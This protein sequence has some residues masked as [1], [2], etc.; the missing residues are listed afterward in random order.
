[1]KRRKGLFGRSKEGKQKKGQQS[2]A[3]L[4][5]NT[6]SKQSLNSSIDSHIERQE[7]QSPLLV[8]KAA[9]DYDIL[10]R[11]P[12]ETS[13]HSISSGTIFVAVN[14]D[15][16]SGSLKSSKSFSS[17][18]SKHKDSITKSPTGLDLSGTNRIKEFDELKLSER[19]KFDQNDANDRE[20]R[21]PP[22][23]TSAN[24]FRMDDVHILS[25]MQ[26][27]S[28]P[29]HM[30][31]NS[32]V[33][34]MNNQ[35]PSTRILMNKLFEIDGDDFVR[36]E[37]YLRLFRDALHNESEEW[38]RSGG[39]IS[40]HPEEAFLAIK[41]SA[42]KFHMRWME[43]KAGRDA[44]IEKAA[45]NRGISSVKNVDEAKII[46]E[47]PSNDGCTTENLRTNSFNTIDEESLNELEQICWDIYEHTMWCCAVL[48]K[49]CV[50]PAWTFQMKNRKN[51]LQ[52]AN[53]VRLRNDQSQSANSVV[54]RNTM[55]TR[56]SR[57]RMISIQEGG[58]PRGM[59]TSK[60]IPFEIS[61]QDLLRYPPIPEVLPIS[62]LRFVAW[63]GD[64][65]LPQAKSPENVILLKRNKN[66]DDIDDN[67]NEYSNGSVDLNEFSISLEQLLWEERRC[68]IRRQRL[69]EAQRELTGAL[70]SKDHEDDAESPFD[71]LS[72][73]GR[74]KTSQYSRRYT[75]SIPGS[76]EPVSIMIRSWVETALLG[77]PHEAAR[78]L[79]SQLCQMNDLESIQ[80]AWSSVVTNGALDWWNAV[81]VSRAV[82]DLTL[83][84]WRPPPEGVHGEQC[85]FQ[86]MT[87]AEKG[88]L[89]RPQDIKN[90]SWV[91]DCSNL[92]KMGVVREER[93][94]A[95]T[96]AADAMVALNHLGTRGCLPS[97]TI[98]TIAS[99]LCYLLSVADKMISDNYEIIF[100]I[101]KEYGSEDEEIQ[102]MANLDEFLRQRDICLHEI[103]ELLWSMM[104]R[105]ISMTLTADALVGVL[106]ID[107]SSDNGR[108]FNDKAFAACGAVRSLGASLWGNL[109]SVKGN[110]YLRICWGIFIDS[111]SNICA[112]MHDKSKCCKSP[113]QP[114]ATLTS[115][116]VA[117]QK[118]DNDSFITI[119]ELN[120][121]NSYNPSSLVLVF[122]I[123][124]AV[125]RLVDGDLASGNFLLCPQEWESLMNLLKIGFLPWLASLYAANNNNPISSEEKDCPTFERNRD[126]V[127]KIQCEVESIFQQ[128]QIYLG[129]NE[130]GSFFCDQVLDENIKK[131][132]FVLYFRMISPLLPLSESIQIC[133]SIID[134]WVRGGAITF[135]STDWQKKCS[136]LLAEAFAVYQDAAQGYDGG[137]VHPPFVRQ[138][139]MR[140][141][142]ENVQPGPGLSENQSISSPENISDNT[143]P[144]FAPLVAKSVHAD[145]VSRVL[146]PYLCEVLF[147]SSK[148][149]GLQLPDR[150]PVLLDK[151]NYGDL[152][153]GTQ[154]LLLSAVQITGDL[155]RSFSLENRERLELIKILRKC[156]L[157]SLNHNQSVPSNGL[158]GNVLEQN[159]WGEMCKVKLEAISQLALFLR[160]CFDT[161]AVSCVP[162]VIKILIETVDTFYY[163]NS[164]IS[165]ILPC[166]I[167]C[168]AAMVQLACIRITDDRKA[169]LVDDD[170]VI[171]SCSPAI[172][173]VIRRIKFVTD[174]IT[175]HNDVD[176]PAILKEYNILYCSSIQRSVV[177]STIKLEKLSDAQ[178]EESPPNRFQVGIVIDIASIVDSIQAVLAITS[179]RTDSS[180]SSQYVKF[181]TNNCDDV[182]NVL[183]AIT[184]EMLDFYIQSGLETK[185]L[186]LWNDLSSLMQLGV[187]NLSQY[188]FLSSCAAFVA[189]TQSSAAEIGLFFNHLLDGCA[190]NDCAVSKICCL[191]LSSYLTTCSL[192]PLE[193][194][195]VLQTWHQEACIAIIARIQL[196]MDSSDNMVETLL[197]TLLHTISTYRPDFHTLNDRT[198]A[199]IVIVCHQVCSEACIDQ[200]CPHLFLLSLQC[201]SIAVSTM[202]MDELMNLIPRIST[203]QGSFT[204]PKGAPDIPE[205]F[206]F[207]STIL[208]ILVQHCIVMAGST[209]ANK[210]NELQFNDTERLAKEI[211]DIETFEVQKENG[212]N[213]AAWLCNDI[214]LM[215]RVG[216]CESKHRGWVEIIL[217][218]PST[219][220]RKLVRLTNEI[221]IQSPDLPS[222]LW[223]IANV[224]NVKNTN[225]NIESGGHTLTTDSEVLTAARNALRKFKSI[226]NLGEISVPAPIKRSPLHST[227]GIANQKS[228]RTKISQSICEGKLPTDNSFQHFLHT[229]LDG[230]KQSIKEVQDVLHQLDGSISILDSVYDFSDEPKPL[231]WCSKLRRAV[232]ILDRTAFL[233]TH[234][235]SLSQLIILTDRQFK[236]YYLIFHICVFQ[237]FDRLVLC[238]LARH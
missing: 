46:E 136:Q 43:L 123:T 107:L 149:N 179:P 154:K 52:A 4:D 146:V 69:G 182:T 16:I 231:Q 94:A 213:V 204:Y 8:A 200:P 147:G 222:N 144:A 156:I 236:S 163:H 176:D 67:G 103:A 181:V 158:L 5:S 177:S 75:L 164:S 34:S 205:H 83:A 79:T 45:E 61:T 160:T 117:N 221:S 153:R 203:R 90:S 216:S 141:L 54:S 212:Q 76:H 175:S 151:E 166:Q 12:L 72:K 111:L 220:I 56:P 62:M 215:C 171:K 71:D 73:A 88:T 167:V 145:V 127:Q 193:G 32:G 30:Q 125:R 187:G 124:V 84:G 19:L 159:D 41:Q 233:Q 194:S 78:E 24:R 195:A 155:L 218:S 85:I 128:L 206:Q 188:K 192:R 31:P 10:S 130:D 105:N 234:K 134:A 138:A 27:S 25:K 109:P 126:L 133:L 87:L 51:R 17:L 165:S 235:V 58:A 115:S 89:L 183:H 118:T 11:H 209:K 132:F 91:E 172:A 106:D 39:E 7:K 223:D 13:H 65:V 114:L 3:G 77:W 131:S 230:D 82:S 211:D 98:K 38:E 121:I 232:N 81:H 20:G 28:I 48:A 219:R 178:K 227:I 186:Q 137:Y 74:S 142:V 225:S 217:R 42:E 47:A 116:S 119:P 6:I 63:L 66:I 229:A 110:Q 185:P 57:Q 150:Y 99:S 228:N 108:D 152:H 197:E 21:I 120:H 22:D 104:A 95:A 174:V 93:L 214:L 96:S 102:V 101:P 55:V 113:I 191:G 2:S 1:M 140:V 23:M 208:D 162:S 50:G 143:D 210:S 161:H 157:F 168:I 36:G 59:H 68:L 49:A 202:G 198:K 40:Y 33:F 189:E 92:K 199:N 135:S 180:D 15:S 169:F 64:A 173:D 100:P 237:I 53:F 196:I 14:E 70:I 129:F 201:A 139:A 184:F 190:S 226:D 170:V 60:E 112:S 224:Q 238:L 26:P 29:L 97:K 207:A 35:W 148:R 122:E 86:L 80:V 44:Q 18:V 9:R 37:R